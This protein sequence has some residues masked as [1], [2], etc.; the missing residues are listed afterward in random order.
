MGNASARIKWS[1]APTILTNSQ[2]LELRNAIADL[3]DEVARLRD[4]NGTQNAV[5]AEHDAALTRHDDDIRRSHIEV[6][7]FGRQPEQA[8]PPQLRTMADLAVPSDMQARGEAWEQMVAGMSVYVRQGVVGAAL[9]DVIDALAGELYHRAG[10]DAR[11]DGIR[12]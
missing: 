5:L 8:N 10:L 4:E 11:L 7:R 6:I 1:D 3:R 9:I 12:L 2:V